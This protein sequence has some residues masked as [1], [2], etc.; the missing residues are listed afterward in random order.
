M[1]DGAATHSIFALNRAPWAN[2]TWTFLA[3]QE[4]TDDL[5]PPDA[6]ALESL[7][8]K[9]GA[10]RLANSNASS[11]ARSAATNNATHHK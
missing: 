7:G 3:L 1:K 11:G 5:F 2:A 8:I 10:E 4:I 9:T 6:L